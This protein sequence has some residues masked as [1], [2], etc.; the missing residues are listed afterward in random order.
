MRVIMSFHADGILLHES[1]GDF[2]INRYK[3]TKRHVFETYNVL[4]NNA[5]TPNHK[6][7][8]KLILST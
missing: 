4:L 5:L 7:S 3:T 2:S 8:Q 6:H 1:L